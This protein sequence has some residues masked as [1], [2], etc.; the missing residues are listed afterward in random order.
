MAD[1]PPLSFIPDETNAL[2]QAS[3]GDIAETIKQSRLLILK[4]R[5]MLK[6]IDELQ[7]RQLRRDD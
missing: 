7:S 5:K 3:P 1:Y 6:Q 4:S 2:M